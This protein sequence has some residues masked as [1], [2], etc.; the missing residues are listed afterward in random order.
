MK[1]TTCY[2]L[3]IA[4]ILLF[5]FVGCGKTDEEKII[6]TWEVIKVD[7]EET[8]VDNSMTFSEDGSVI[9]IIGSDTEQAQYEI[10]DGKIIFNIGQLNVYTYTSD[11][12]LEKNILT[13]Y[14][15]NGADFE[16]KK[17]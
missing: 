13:I 17:K 3:A 16:L 10:A 7:G 1:K 4:M 12:K 9:L 14:D 5:L 2:Y 8:E 15:F 11:Y 6:G